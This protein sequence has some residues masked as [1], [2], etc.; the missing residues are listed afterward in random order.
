[1]HNK[2]GDFILSDEI[3]VMHYEFA[4]IFETRKQALNFMNDHKLTHREY[5]VIEEEQVVSSFLERMNLIENI[6]ED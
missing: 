3:S 5:T 2:S 1:M 6:F 4:H